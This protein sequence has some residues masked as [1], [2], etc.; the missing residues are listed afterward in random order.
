MTQPRV[1]VPTLISKL[2]F[3]SRPVS[4][5][6]SQPVT[7]KRTTDTTD[8]THNCFPNISSPCL[9]HI[10]RTQ[11]CFLNRRHSQTRR[12]IR[13][14]M[15]ITS[16][17][18]E[19]TCPASSAT[20]SPRQLEPWDQR[21]RLVRLFRLIAVSEKGPALWNTADHLMA[22]SPKASPVTKH[23]LE[24]W[25]LCCN[26]W[27]KTIKGFWSQQAPHASIDSLAGGSGDKGSGIGWIT[28]QLRRWTATHI[29]SWLHAGLQR[30]RPQ[31]LS[32]FIVP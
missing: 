20:G 28:I 29:S 1:F 18:A 21:Q 6:I 12:A 19:R 25:R 16:F 32:A 5:W 22:A 24:G 10:I 26:A 14:E 11:I 15:I 8:M 2:V 3:I 13:R 7:P 27:G 4:S 30:Q 9:G 17:S 31:I 23:L